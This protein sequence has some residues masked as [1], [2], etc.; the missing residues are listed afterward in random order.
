MKKKI[1]HNQSD[2]HYLLG[3]ATST[4]STGRNIADLSVMT[5]RLQLENQFRFA[6]PKNRNNA[7]LI[8]KN[9]KKRETRT[10]KHTHHAKRRN[11]YFYRKND[12]DRTVMGMLKVIESLSDW[13]GRTLNEAKRLPGLPVISSQY[14]DTRRT[15]DSNYADLNL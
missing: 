3:P 9:E 4:P 11:P 12:F 10:H 8:T 14:P 1:Q 7:K 5:C 13:G 2:H 6:R 15:Y